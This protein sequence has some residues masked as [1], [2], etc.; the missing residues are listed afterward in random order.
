MTDGRAS[1]PGT[2]P[3]KRRR[4][5]WP[6]P[7]SDR[8]GRIGP[9]GSEALPVAGLLLAA[10]F[11]IGIVV[12]GGLHGWPR[13]MAR[14]DE[15][16]ATAEP[17]ASGVSLPTDRLRER[18]FDQAKRLID[19]GRMADAATLLDEMLAAD[20][21]I[22]LDEGLAEWQPRR[23]MKTRVAELIGSLPP[24][25]REAYLLQFRSRAER[26]LDAAIAA[27]DLEQ[28]IAVARRWLHTPAGGRAALV[29][30]T[31]L[32]EAGQ[33]LAAAAWLDRLTAERLADL[34]QSIATAAT[35]MRTTARLAAA[36]QPFQAP[37]ADLP[38]PAAV[39]LGG[40]QLESEGE[41]AQALLTRRLA[42]AVQSRPSRPP[43]AGP[44]WRLD[45]GAP[46]RNP[47]CDC[48]RPLL[49]PRYRVPLTL[50][51]MEAQLV[52]DRR[53]LLRDQGLPILPA[54]SPLAVNGFIL[55]QS[56]AGLVAIDFKTGK[57]V[58]L[59][60]RL[61]AS[62]IVDG[63]DNQLEDGQQ[64]PLD[65]LFD[66]ATSATLASN[67]RLV[68]AVE[69]PT[70]IG[71]PNRGG[72][73]LRRLRRPQATAISNRLVAY[74]IEAKGEQR[75]AV[76][77]NN[78]DAP[79]RWYLG[80]P[81]PLG[82]ELYVLVEERQQIRLDVLE[83]STGETLWSQPLADIDL[84]QG[85]ENRVDR[86]RAGLSPAFA[87]GILACPT[88]AGAVIAVDL[89]ARALRWAYRFPLPQ[90]ADVRRLANGIRLRLGV[91]AGGQVVG[92]V[93]AQVNAGGEAPLGRWLDAT[94][95]V[96]GDRVL[97]TPPG[98]AEL[99]CIDLR[100][101]ERRW[102][103]PR[104]DSL[105]VAGVVDRRVILV[106]Q[107]QARAVSLDDGQPLWEKP[108]VFADQQVCGRPLLSSSRLFVPLTTPA[109]AELD[110]ATGQLLGSSPGRGESLPGNLVAHRGEIISQGIDSLDIF[111]QTVPLERAVETAAR[112]N[113][114]D[115]WAIAWRGELRLAAGKTEAG[116]EDIQRAHGPDGLQPAP[117]IVS[118][119]VRHA[120]VHDFPAAA[121]WWRE[122]AAAADSPAAKG[123]IL[124]QAIAGFLAEEDAENAWPVCLK[125]LGMP[126]AATGDQL[127]AD[128]RDR[129]LLMLEDRWLG[130]QLRRLH[131]AARPAAAGEESVPAAIDSVAAAAVTTA[132]EVGDLPER[133]AALEQVVDRFGGHP[134]ARRAREQLSD[135]VIQQAGNTS[136]P[137]RQALRLQRELLELENSKPP[138]RVAGEPAA[139][140]L[141]N[142]AWP[143][144]KV[145]VTDAAATNESAGLVR[146]R[147]AVPL[148]H[149]EN[150]AFPEAT[151]ETDGSSLLLQDRL[152][153]QIG[154][155]LSLVGQNRGSRRPFSQLMRSQGSEA[156]MVGR[157]LLLATP[158]ELAA[159]EVND[160][161]A[162]DHRLLW[163]TEN[164]YADA[165]QQ[166]R[167]A[168]IEPFNERLLRLVHLGRLAGR[169]SRVPRTPI[170]RIGVPQLSGV[171]VIYDRTLELRDLQTG[172][173][174]WQRRQIPPRAEAFGDG[175]V[176]C[177]AGPDG[178]DSM[179]LSMDDGRLLAQHDLPPQDLRL[180]TAGR[181]L[182]V[183]GP[184]TGDQPEG[185]IGLAS[186]DVLDRSRTDVASVSQNARGAGGP[187]GMFFTVN[188]DGRLTAI[189]VAAGRAVFATDLP[190]PP[191]GLSN[192]RIL[193]WQ[194]RYLVVVGRTETAA[195]QARFA[196]IR[197]IARFGSNRPSHV[198]TS[199]LYAVDRLS[200][201]LLWSRPAS[202]QRHIL[203][204]PQPAALPV[205]LFAREL[206]IDRGSRQTL[207]GTRHGV[208]C[209]DKRTGGLL[210]LDDRIVIE[211]RHAAATA[212]L[213]MVGEPATS[214]IRLR[215]ES[216][217]RGGTG[218][219]DIL[220]RFTG[221]PAGS[222]LPFRNEEHELVYTD[223]ASEVS[224]WAGRLMQE[225]AEQI[226]SIFD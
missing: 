157:I 27:D 25:G 185:G 35:L 138:N 150:S 198:E 89:A 99:H 145:A 156:V 122:G 170:F 49:V 206:R 201:D 176:L 15:A 1:R 105:L 121:P 225:A 222:P 66:D 45:R 152:G 115:P 54:G 119:A 199:L 6:G 11:C 224:F 83:A 77:R 97:L 29:V 114:A 133:I 159:F 165:L 86:R 7:G 76:P 112:E 123:D 88:G 106:G 153:G 28:I 57:R 16:D 69:S 74:D 171:P 144:G 217:Q 113:P 154:G 178:K 184:A 81:L 202:I 208:L 102:K 135:A 10:G 64:H 4:N 169:Q 125:L 62:A 38:Q 107:Q 47:V 196:N 104:G 210:H 19:A 132:A 96:L 48:D 128:P 52:A 61:A 117:A 139:D 32:L 223:V 13:A 58:W 26:A 103:I 181:R 142:T 12:L 191:A 98:S 143:V 59:Q 219:R 109:V 17:L 147:L 175:D 31:S 3:A 212:E 75:W 65:R 148:A 9:G 174:L 93:R 160:D 22:F 110:V 168:Q 167:M 18:Q 162:T 205:L 50:H 70:G 39:T 193:P 137:A 63:D 194:D 8:R 23:S 124:R 101:G 164:P 5:R 209:L 108:T 221:L 46:N 90:P 149:A 218:S 140:R 158:D 127:V 215:I 67:G 42:A 207:D 95:T 60:G 177:V 192:L 151:L 195:E 180:A 100:S 55:A 36:S 190:E 116:L 40:E 24:A 30:A 20:E 220:L 179:V 68:F 87:G 85:I 72:N 34:P 173:L 213:R 141:A 126:P 203:H 146:N 197:G 53:Q 43:E 111:H 131:H 91:L 71:L 80:S 51:P 84:E 73:R 161:P 163:M 21:D 172:R 187:P 226:L 118:R 189:D 204:S 2:E 216:R 44:D 37:S 14:A 214:T 129:H 134:I 33:P 183:I 182:L 120:L 166:Q 78:D 82:G 94:P 211:P 188:N 56:R 92:G 200:G 79:G 130:S 136:G 186:L 155:G 41:V